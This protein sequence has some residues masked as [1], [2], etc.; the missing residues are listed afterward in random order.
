MVKD[1]VV[2]FPDQFETEIA[3]AE[4][5]YDLI[6]ERMARGRLPNEVAQGGDVAPLLD[7]VGELLHLDAL[8]AD[9]RR[10]PEKK[11]RKTVTRLESAVYRFGDWPEVPRLLAMTPLIVALEELE[12]PGLATELIEVW[13]TERIIHSDQGPGRHD[14]GDWLDE[15]DPDDDW[16][17]LDPDDI[18]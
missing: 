16:D 1:N 8:A 11:M 5:A 14:D 4:R 2:E 13:K 6:L 18:D 17:D 10:I 9:G 12:I 3:L 7:A 15:E